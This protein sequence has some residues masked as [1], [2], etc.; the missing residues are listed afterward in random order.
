M[1]LYAYS[2]YIITGEILDYVLD[3]TIAYP[4]T[5]PQNESDIIR[6]N[7]PSEIHFLVNR[8]P[9]SK[10]P[11]HKDDLDNW[12]KER[13]NKKEMTLKQFYDKK[14]FQ[15]DEF[16]LN[17]NESLVNSLFLYAWV[18]WFALKLAIA[19]ILWFY[20]VWW[21]YVAAC[22]VFYCVVSKF[23]KGFNILIADAFNV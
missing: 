16:Q 2:C 14:S 17:S 12:C 15:Q 23:T 5:I 22:T 3:I 7:F 9:N 20:P 8:F 6:G 1:T 18:S 19:Y 11:S 13:W 10:I 21:W 4:G